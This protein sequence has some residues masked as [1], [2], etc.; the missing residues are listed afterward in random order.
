MFEFFDRAF[1]FTPRG[2]TLNHLLGAHCQIGGKDR[3]K[4]FSFLVVDKNDFNGSPE[5]TAYASKL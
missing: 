1:D 2:V 4:S 5:A 3:E